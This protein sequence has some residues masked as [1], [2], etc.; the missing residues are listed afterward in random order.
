MNL[1][2]L[3]FWFNFRP[4]PLL[5]IYSNILIIFVVLLVV[6]IF[7][8]N[9][10]FKNKKSLYYD[11]VEKIKLFSW[12]NAFFGMLLLFFNYEQVPFFSSRFWYAI[13]AISM[14]IWIINI[15]KHFKKIPERKRKME[16]HKKYKKYIP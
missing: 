16:E 4:G 7:I 8:S 13:W 10:I 2:S 9:F 6:F 3:N 5:S 11:V 1:L 15:F 14:F 12:L